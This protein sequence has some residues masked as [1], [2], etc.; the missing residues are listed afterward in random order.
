[1]LRLFNLKPTSSFLVNSLDISTP[2][3]R[4]ALGGRQEKLDLSAC[5]G[6]L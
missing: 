6:L 5:K 1:M 2:P 4:V 3:V